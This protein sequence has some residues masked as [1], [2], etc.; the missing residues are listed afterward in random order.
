[1]QSADS[2]VGRKL[3]KLLAQKSRKALDNPPP[4]NAIADKPVPTL[5]GP[6]HLSA[7]LIALIDRAYHL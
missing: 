6:T 7:V 3:A 4:T 2:I 5:I 1:M